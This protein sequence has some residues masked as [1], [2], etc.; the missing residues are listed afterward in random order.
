MNKIIDSITLLLYNIFL[1]GYFLFVLIASIWNKKAK[2]WIAGRKNIFQK[3][4]EAK[5][6]HKKNIWMHV[7]SLG[8]FEQGRPIIELLKKQYP[9]YKI[10]LSFFSP[11]GFEIRKDYE[12][13]DHIFYLPH[14]GKKN[15]RKFIELINPKIAIFVK[16]DFWYWY[17]KNLHKKNIPLI[18]VSSIFKKEQLFFKKFTGIFKRI[19]LYVNYF[20]VQDTPSKQLLNKYGYKNVSVIPD[21]R[22]DRV[23]QIC[24]EAGKKEIELIEKFKNKEQLLI[25]G[26]S[27]ETEEKY[28]HKLISSSTFKGKVILAPHK[29]DEKHISFIKNLFGNEALFWSEVKDNK[30]I[31]TNKQIFVIN[32]IGL[33]QYLYQYADIAI[34]GGGFNKSIHNTLEPATFGI[35]IIFGPNSHENF[36]EA[37]KLIKLKGAFLIN[38]YEDLKS[39]ISYLQKEKNILESGEICKN[40]I[41]DNTG[42]SAK[43]VSFI[44]KYL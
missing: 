18:L 37:I 5:L 39:T 10:I 33:L 23:N 21:T 26:S 15:S 7:A 25:V 2:Q 3:I 32:T 44:S 17:F 9:D 12:F 19:L 27:Y 34:I 20:F 36:N 6:T 11:S 8:E 22:I 1:K 28:I 43:V 30:K 14:D 41:K 29:I 16:Y 24:N 40:F 35:P 31:D 13:A 38:N 42:G 4:E